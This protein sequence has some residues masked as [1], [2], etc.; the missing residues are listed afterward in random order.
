MLTYLFTANYEFD[1]PLK[2]HSN[3][4]LSI[5]YGANVYKKTAVVFYYLQQYLGEEMFDKCMQYYFSQ[6]KFKHPQPKDIRACFEKTSG[7]NLDW[8]FSSFI[9]SN[10]KADFSIRCDKTK[11]GESGTKQMVA[12]VRN[13][14]SIT[15]PCNVSMI[16]KDGKVST[17]W[18]TPLK[19][20]ESGKVVFDLK[21]NI[22]IEKIVANYD[23]V[24]PEIS[25]KNNQYRLA[26]D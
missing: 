23:T 16:D 19:P 5:N 15:G 20:G 8:F 13:F 4:Y 7:Q 21:D 22:K 24:I 6:W 3:D 26:C 12:K 10:G 17:L 14:G 9:D 25:Y 11:K 2:C 1:Q 18:T